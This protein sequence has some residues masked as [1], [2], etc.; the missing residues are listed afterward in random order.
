MLV[1]VH[2]VLRVF[3]LWSSGWKENPFFSLNLTL[4]SPLWSFFVPQGAEDDLRK[5]TDMAYKQ[6]NSSFCG[7]LLWERGR[8]RV[9]TW[10]YSSSWITLCIYSAELRVNFGNCRPEVGVA[11]AD[12]IYDSFGRLWRLEWTLVLGIFHFPLE[13]PA[14]RPRSF[15]V[16]N[17]LSSWMRY[18]VPVTFN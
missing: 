7:V 9:E 10:N 11:S 4:L 17:L 3:P 2:L 8:G 16:I 14:S 5:V 13:N 12:C 6:V 18:D 1:V 15:T